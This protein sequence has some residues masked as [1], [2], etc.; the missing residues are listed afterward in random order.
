MPPEVMLIFAGIA[1]GFGALVSLIVWLSRA[2]DAR[3]VRWDGTLLQVTWYHGAAH[4]Y[5]WEQLS[6]LQLGS[7]RQQYGAGGNYATV[8]TAT[9]QKWTIW[10]RNS[11]YTEL[12][13]ALK[14]HVW[15]GEKEAEPSP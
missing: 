4:R 6:Q 14:A 8:H 15:G 11:G 7:V 12:A 1:F 2:R 9:G 13:E 10:E 5:H 3:L